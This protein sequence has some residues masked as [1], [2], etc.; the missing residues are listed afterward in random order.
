MKKKKKGKEKR[1]TIDEIEEI[2]N[3]LLNAENKNTSIT[4]VTPYKEEVTENGTKKRFY[5]IKPTK[6]GDVDHCIPK[7]LTDK[8][9]LPVRVDRYTQTNQRINTKILDPLNL[10]I[11]SSIREDQEG[12]LEFEYK[13]EGFI[14][15]T[16]K[17]IESG[18]YTAYCKKNGQWKLYNDSS[19]SVVDESAAKKAAEDGY[20]YI[21]RKDTR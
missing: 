17:T 21:Y 7:E 6:V 19:V 10:I 16:G 1:Y 8:D 2:K 12:P 15:Q 5:Y 11:P 9:L 13:L 18:H 14:A 4:Y 20:V 3:V